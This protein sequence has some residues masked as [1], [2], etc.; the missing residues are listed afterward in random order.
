MKLIIFLVLFQLNLTFFFLNHRCC[1]LWIKEELLWSLG[2]ALF[3]V[4]LVKVSRFEFS[5]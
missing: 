1:V 5:L 3:S 2:L 4:S